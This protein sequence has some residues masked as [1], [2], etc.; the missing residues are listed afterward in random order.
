[1]VLKQF[2]TK[3]ICELL[4]IS[5]PFISKW[6]RL[7]ELNGANALVSGYKGSEGFLSADM[8]RAIISHLKEKMHVSIEELR[9]Y[10]ED[11]YGV[12]YKSKQSYYDL[13]REAGL[14]WHKSQKIN[15]AKNEARVLLKREE[16]GKRLMEHEEEIKSAELWTCAE[17]T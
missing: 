7:Y 16:I 4:E 10:L 11:R 2:E 3:D 8:K 9:D 1:M 5:N 14:S 15:P 12:V 17:I 6:K 13:M